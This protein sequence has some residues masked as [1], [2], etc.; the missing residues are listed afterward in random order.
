MKNQML[1]PFKVNINKDEING[2]KERLENTRFPDEEI[3]ALGENDIK[4]EKMKEWI[5]HWK[6]DYD[7]FNLENKLNKFEQYRINI[8]N[9]LIHFIHIP[10]TKDDS[11]PLLMIHGW[12]SSPLE[13][14]EISKLL[15]DDYELII[16]TIPG[17][18][19]SGQAEHWNTDKAA[20]AFLRLMDILGKTKYVI[21]G[22][23]F[24]ASIARKMAILEPDKILGIH[25][26][27]L[28]YASATEED[29]NRDDLEENASL[30]AMYKYQYESSGYAT[31]QSLKPQD[32]SYAMSDSPSGL[33]AWI[34]SAF[35]NWRDPRKD[36]DINLLLDTTMIY[37]LYNTLGSSVRYYKNE[38]NDWVSA[39]SFCTVPT[40]VTVMPYD[41]AL[42]I[43]RIA[44]KS[45]NIVQWNKSEYG[46]HFSTIE[47]PKIIA[48]NLIY[49]KGIL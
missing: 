12:P 39:P 32:I 44:E 38:T 1:I 4:L 21:H 6:N 19:I 46:G 5:N 45:D 22:G 13:F 10:S 35:L 36:L 3:N 30:E 24:G 33:L 29:I 20:T 27:Q 43:K 48:D 40:A 18:G 15:M 47:A 49:F 37:W 7:F 11:L 25:V 34:G 9:H 8:D 23:D 16:P 41:V 17:F 26:T 42:P 2:L 14:L 31:I 28:S